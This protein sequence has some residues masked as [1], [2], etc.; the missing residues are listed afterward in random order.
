MNS[1]MHKDVGTNGTVD[2]VN[3]INVLIVGLNF[4]APQLAYLASY[5]ANKSS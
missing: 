5:I 4:K 3:A 2:D 1:G